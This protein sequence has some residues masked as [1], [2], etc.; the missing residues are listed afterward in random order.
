MLPGTS[1]ALKVSNSCI[2]H[3]AS[4][5]SPRNTRFDSY[6]WLGDNL[7]VHIVPSFSFAL[8][9]LLTCLNNHPKTSKLTIAEP[10]HPANIVIN[11]VPIKPI[12]MNAGINPT[13]AAAI[14]G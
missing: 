7:G 5:I 8:T 9:S 12:I 1:M 14:Y 4:E 13:N 2:S 10:P 3:T 11:D 6:L